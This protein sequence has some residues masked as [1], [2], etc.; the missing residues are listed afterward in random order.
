MSPVVETEYYSSW[1]KRPDI[2]T[3]ALLY[4]L[5]STGPY[6]FAIDPLGAATT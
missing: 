1:G 4:L 3:K 6:T 2:A 5:P